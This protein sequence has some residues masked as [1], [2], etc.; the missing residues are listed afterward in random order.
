MFI[1]N[2]ICTFRFF[3]SAAAHR[4]DSAQAI[5]FLG[6]LRRPMLAQSLP[7]SPRRGLKSAVVEMPELESASKRPRNVLLRRLDVL[8]YIE[9]TDFS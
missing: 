5:F 9:M 2:V 7:L 1:L 8:K 4:S 6:R 3:A